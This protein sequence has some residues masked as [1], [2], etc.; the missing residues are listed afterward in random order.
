MWRAFGE[1]LETLRTG[2]AV[3]DHP[4]FSDL[5]P[6][7]TALVS[8]TMMGFAGDEPA[9][10]AEAYDFSGIRTLV[11]VGGNIGSLL[12]TILLANPALQGILFELPHVAAGARLLLEN[13][14]VADRCDVVSGNFFEAVPAGGDAYL[15]SHVVHDWPEEKC[16]ALL[17]N[18]RRVIPKLGRL[19]LVE[20]IIPSKNE[21]HP[22]RVIDLILLAVTG[23]EERTAE[24]YAALLAKGGFQ[25]TRVVP[26]RRGVSV[27]EAAPA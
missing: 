17:R 7:Q 6:E 21:P 11:D 15:L 8:E 27:V 5:G 13:R 22:S 12:T 1:L 20:H 19:L 16:L 4:I 14:G 18:V 25:I 3:V 24:E 9:A 26:T 2:E 23:G 10:V